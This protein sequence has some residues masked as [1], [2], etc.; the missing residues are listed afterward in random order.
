MNDINN[1]SGYLKPLLL[2]RKFSRQSPFL[3][4]KNGHKMCPIK[5]MASIFVLVKQILL[6]IGVGLLCYLK[7][8]Y[9]RFEIK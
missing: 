3:I 4:P 1:T 7:K 6:A 9:D 8:Y 2:L 5:D